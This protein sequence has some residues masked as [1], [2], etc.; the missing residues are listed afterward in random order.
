MHNDEFIIGSPLFK[1][2]TLNLRNGNTFTIEAKNNSKNNFYIQSA[3][4]ND[5]DYQNSF[6]KCSDIQKGGLLEFEVSNTPN[7]SWGSKAENLPFSLSRK[8]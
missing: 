3:R 4:L 2:V 5:S 7:K 8:K 1:K 6:I